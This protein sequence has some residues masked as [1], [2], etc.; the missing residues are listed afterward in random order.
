MRGLIVWVCHYSFLLFLDVFLSEFLCSTYYTSLLAMVLLKGCGRVEGCF[1]WTLCS[2]SMWKC[3]ST[4]E[5]KP[6]QLPALTYT[7]YHPVLADLGL[8]EILGKDSLFSLSS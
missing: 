2:S 6:Y 5:L 1:T 8:T 7:G 4:M 3:Q